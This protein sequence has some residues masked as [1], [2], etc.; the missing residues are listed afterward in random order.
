MIEGKAVKSEIKSLYINGARYKLELPLMA[1]ASPP[2]GASLRLCLSKNLIY[3][4]LCK[5]QLLIKTFFPT[6][7]RT[8][9]IQAKIIIILK[10]CVKAQ[11]ETCAI[12]GLPRLKILRICYLITLGILIMC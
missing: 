12:K 8:S 9:H 11:V 3:I 5:Q 10:S 2:N 7:S 4:Y 6:K 1:Q